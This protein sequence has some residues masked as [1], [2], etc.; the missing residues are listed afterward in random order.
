[1]FEAL[2]VSLGQ[3]KLLAKEDTGRVHPEG[4]F[5]APDFRIVLE[6]GTQ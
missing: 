3:Y 4:R 6:N 2:V 5:T 1:M